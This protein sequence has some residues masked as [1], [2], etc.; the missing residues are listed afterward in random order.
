MALHI[1]IN[2]VCTLNPQKNFSL[3]SPQ[4][5]SLS[6]STRTKTCHIASAKRVK[7]D[8]KNK[9]GGIS[10]TFKEDEI[11][12]DEELD[13]AD[14]IDDGYF[15]PE[16]PGDKPDPFEGEQWDALGFF[17]Q[18]QWAF[19]ILFAL[20]AC[21]IAVATYN[22]GATDFK[23][24][25]VYQESIQSRELLEEPEASN[26]DIFEGNPTEDAPSVE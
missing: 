21:G 22:E 8:S 15:L 26:S 11:A 24:T 7:F 14:D 19:G 2:G 18:Y 23:K 4:T 3:H 13:V 25:P 6:F 1:T 10:T 12:E 20:V 5:P 16:L 9:K 17:V